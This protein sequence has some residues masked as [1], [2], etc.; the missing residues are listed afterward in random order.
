MKLDSFRH[1]FRLLR[2]EGEEY[3]EF[4]LTLY[5][6][7]SRLAK[8]ERRGYTIVGDRPPANL[9]SALSPEEWGMDKKNDSER[10]IRDQERIIMTLGFRALWYGISSE[11]E[12][13]EFDERG[14]LQELTNFN[15][16]GHRIK[17]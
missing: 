11:I 15:T 14:F 10:I 4:Q 17:P 2:G 8:Y 13:M 16:E 1:K 9:F 12:Y 3:R 5:L 7:A 6:A